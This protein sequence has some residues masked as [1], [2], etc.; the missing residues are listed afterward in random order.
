MYPYLAGKIGNTTIYC[1]IGNSLAAIGAGLMTLFTPFSSTGVWV[2]YQ[3]LAGVGRG[4]TLQQPILAVQQT[5]E[6]SKISIGA[7]MVV[8]CQ[9][10]GGAL[11]PAI[12]ETDLSSSL[13]S[14]L[15]QDA[16]GVNATLIFNAGATGL[17][18]I[19][20]INQLPEVLSAYNKAI[21]NTFVSI[22]F[23]DGFSHFLGVL[24]K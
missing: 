7:A 10:F 19:V 17:R 2:G 13:K 9:F 5:L 4:I 8:F 21:I 3:I 18:S 22:K 23:G 1:L 20:S 11:F 6:P 15:P 24:T 12:A 16:P 14:I